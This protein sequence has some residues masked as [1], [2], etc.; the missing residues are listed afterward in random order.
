MVRS[1]FGGKASASQIK[2][3]Y[4]EYAQIRAKG[5]AKSLGARRT[6]LNALS[7]PIFDGHGAV[8]VTVTALGMA[9][10]F[11]ADLRGDLAQ[12][13]LALSH[14]LSAQLGFARAADSA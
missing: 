2:A 8:L 12:Q 5:I 6:G 4:A 3:V 11:S 9:P 13:M 14:E 10:R 1:E 7:V